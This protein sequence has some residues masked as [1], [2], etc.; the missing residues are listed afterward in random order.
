M[1]IRKVQL[2]PA[3]C[4]V[5]L[6][7]GSERGRYVNQDYIL[8]RMGRPHR[9]INL[10]FCYYPFDKEWPARISEVVKAADKTNA[11][12]YPYDDYEPFHGEEPFRRLQEVRS[13]GQDAILT[14]TCD[15][16]VTDDMITEI[17]KKLRP[18]GRLMLRLNHEATG[19]WFS[20]NKRASY[21][22]VADFFVRFRRV[23][24][25]TAPNVQVILC[26]GGVEGDPNG[27]MEKEAEFTEAVRNS[28]IW[29]IDQYLSLNWAYPNEIAEKDNHGHKTVHINRVFEIVQKSYERFRYLNGGVSRPMQICEFNDDGDVLG[30]AAQARRVK[31]FYDLVKEKGRGW[32]TGITM[33]QFRDDGRLGLER[34][35]PSNENEGIEQPLMAAYRD[36]IH[37]PFY[38]PTQE[39]GPETGDLSLRWGGA[40]DSEGL[41]M[42]IAMEGDPVFFEAEFPGELADMN[43]MLEIRDRWFCK[44]P[45]VDRVELLPAFW[46]KPLAGPETVTLNLYAPP[47]DGMNPDTGAADWDINY[48]TTLPALP[49]LRIRYEGAM[50]VPED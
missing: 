11:W 39:I 20:F 8:Q 3:Q 37:D 23:L 25:K 46:D 13:H 24:Q 2:K 44:K 40:E 45:G 6:G 43:L 5:D 48:Y 21:Q 19:S 7:D 36:V 47:A 34:T 18:F 15:P 17:A 29:S 1:K 38:L 49:A 4:A 35:D 50:P 14:I 28:D 12:G 31:A 26:L 42:E 16:A 33:Y 9:A 22:E 27:P 32:L 30:P 41:S 10:M